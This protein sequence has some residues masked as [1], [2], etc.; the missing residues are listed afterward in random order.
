MYTVFWILFEVRDTS[1]L[2][3]R[4]DAP[5]FQV[6]VASYLNVCMFLLPLLD[7]NV[8]FDVFSDAFAYFS[9]FF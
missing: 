4:Q 7:H 6:S 8:Y 5:K 1:G 2:L 3:G 9:M